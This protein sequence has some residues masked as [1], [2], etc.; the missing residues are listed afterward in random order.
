MAASVA[1]PG[2]ALAGNVPDLYEARVPVAD[3]G[4]Q[5]L[6]Q[7]FADALGRVL[8]K[9]SGRRS[10]PGGD[11]MANA[12][13]L[14]R[15]Y[16][17][18]AA[19]LIRVQFDP[20]AIRGRLDGA[21]LPVWGA[22]RPTT[23]VW[24]VPPGRGDRPLDDAPVAAP[25]PAPGGPGGVDSPAGS[26]AE[27]AEDALRRAVREVA[28]VRGLPVL[29]PPGGVAGGPQAVARRLG[30]PLVLVG[31]PAPDDGRTWRWTLRPAVDEP[32]A[33]GEPAWTGDAA[34]GLH[35]LADRLATRY[36]T[37]IA[38]IR[39]ATL[40]VSGVRNFGA[41][42]RLQ[43][44]LEGLDDVEGVVIR[45]VRGDVLVYTLTVRA[46]P[47][48]LQELLIRQ[49][50]LVPDPGGAGSGPDLLRYLLAPEAP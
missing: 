17:P 25:A 13:S 38:A 1:V 31:E 33:A 50:V 22:D 3:A 19:G 37:S 11:L 9:V 24:L 2:L 28:A 10:L 20:A 47:Q 14:V 41:Y 29:L 18:L 42:T 30:V 15:Q 44:F 7:A 6:D 49:G 34:T 5:A 12:G 43:R 35:G 27:S 16:Q 26:P 21:G 46:D 45:E 32:A 39:Q 36:A 8:V 40:L 23:L 48:R 4:A